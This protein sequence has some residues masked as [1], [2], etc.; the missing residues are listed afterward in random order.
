MVFVLLIQSQIYSGTPRGC[1]RPSRGPVSCNPQSSQTAATTT[2]TTTD[3]S[4]IMTSDNTSNQADDTNKDSSKSYHSSGSINISN[5][6]VNKS[7]KSIPSGQNPNNP[8]DANS[9]KKVLN[10][11][12]SYNT[13]N[14]SINLI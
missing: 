5:Q 3:N 13:T 14:K 9:D 2:I 6:E 1:W 8:I 11:N 10:D 12:N 7:D 4:N